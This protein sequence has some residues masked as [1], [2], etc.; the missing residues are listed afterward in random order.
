VTEFTD[1]PNIRQIASDI[2]LDVAEYSP[3]LNVEIRYVWRDEHTTSKGAP[4][5]GKARKISGLNAHL[6]GAREPA[7]GLFVVEIAADLWPK[8]EADQRRALVD[9]ELAHLHVDYD[10]ETGEPMLSVRG[11]DVEEFNSVVRR[12][13]AWRPELSLMAELAGQQR[14]LR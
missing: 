3:L 5:F 7:S 12:H 14:L 2:I 10:D 4:V 9:H 13:G 8:L 6:A 1:A 11:H